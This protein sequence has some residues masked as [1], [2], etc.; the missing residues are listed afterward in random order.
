MDA[1]KAFDRIEWKYMFEVMKRFGFG[2]GFL[3]W[4]RLL[5]KAPTASVLTNGLLSALFKVKRG[6]AQGSPLSPILFA[7]ATEP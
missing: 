6:T 4:I 5:Y 1:E 3:G 7:L 2:C